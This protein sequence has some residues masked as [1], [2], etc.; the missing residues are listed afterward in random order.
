MDLCALA[1]YRATTNPIL[2]QRQLSELVKAEDALVRRCAR[3]LARGPAD[4]DD[5]FQAGCI[6]LLTAI[7]KFDPSRGAWTQYAKQWIYNSMHR[8]VVD[9]RNDVR[10][11]IDKG[12]EVRALKRRIAKAETSTGRTPTQAEL[13]ASDELWT[14]VHREGSEPIVFPDGEQRHRGRQP[15]GNNPHPLEV[16][17]D[18]VILPK[19]FWRALGSLTPQEVRVLTALVVDEKQVKE[20]AEAEGHE[21]RWARSTYKKALEK[22]RAAMAVP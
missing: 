2:R 17:V 15:I 5:L 1:T 13:G 11:P 22:M 8:E 19:A 18:P 16:P 21:E 3:K 7:E 10:L 12:K 6:G 14:L 9:L 4:E 20:V